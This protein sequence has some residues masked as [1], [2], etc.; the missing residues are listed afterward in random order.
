VRVRTRILNL[1]YQLFEDLAVLEP[2]HRLGP[3]EVELQGR[4]QAENAREAE[5][6]LFLFVLLLVEFIRNQMTEAAVIPV[7]QVV[8][9]VYQHSLV[10]LKVVPLIALKNEALLHHPACQ[11]ADDNLVDHSQGLL[12]AQV[13]KVALNGY[14]RVIVADAHPDLPLE[15]GVAQVGPAREVG[16]AVGAV[17]QRLQQLDLLFVVVDLDVALGMAV[18][19]E[20][21]VV[22]LLNRRQDVQLEN[23]QQVAVTAG[24]Q[25]EGVGDLRAEDVV[26]CLLV[27]VARAVV[28]L[29][30]REILHVGVVHGAVLEIRRKPAVGRHQQ[31]PS[32]VRPHLDVEEGLPQ[33]QRSDLQLMQHIRIKVTL[34]AIGHV[35]KGSRGTLPPTLELETQIVEILN[36][37]RRVNLDELRAQLLCN[38]YENLDS[39]KG[40]GNFP[41]QIIVESCGN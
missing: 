31:H 39:S 37:L 2:A 13:L 28:A 27:P 25:G 38:F 6:V 26:D 18:E 20:L 41:C 9:A 1:G 33:P 8:A 12:P 35:Q 24:E 30:N 16:H 10:V 5:Q 29:L 14:G 7:Y 4:R 11:F 22:G 19:D 40:K 34:V 32:L 23:H 21:V 17:P 15:F 3:A 36:R